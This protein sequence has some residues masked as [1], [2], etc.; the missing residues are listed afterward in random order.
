[1]KVRIAVAPGIEPLDRAGLAE[2]ADQLE[3]LGFDTIWLSDV[4]M[5]DVIDPLVGL[6]F[7]A[8][9][10]ERL[11]LGANIVPIGRNPMLLAKALAQ[12]DRLSDGRVLLS[13]VPGLNQPGEREALGVTGDRGAHLDEVIPLIRRWWAGETVDHHSDR[14]D[15]SG[16][17]VRPT[18]VQQPLEIWLGGIGPKAL[19]RTGRLADGWLGAAVTP[20][21]AGA[22]R[23]TIAAAAAEA[24]RT[25]DPE[26]F[27]LSIPYARTEPSAATVA[28]LQARRPDADPGELLPVGARALRALVSELVDQGVSKFVVRP[29]AP[30]PSWTDELTWLADT[31]LELQT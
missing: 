1:V 26:H 7:V 12:L 11:K 22:V 10:T 19:A 31:L 3:A 13:F 27:G 24:G 29:V 6:P 30:V 20:V 18:P 2:L 25:I 21:E 28:A 14:F 17:A 23:A 9:R 16:I 15:F 8:G 4:P 5:A